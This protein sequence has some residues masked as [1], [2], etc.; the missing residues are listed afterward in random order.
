MWLY[1][2]ML[3]AVP[4]SFE[5]PRTGLATTTRFGEPGTARRADRD[6]ARTRVFVDGATIP[7][8]VRHHG[9]HDRR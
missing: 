1:G 8:V 4:R 3:P 2:R 7:A 6:L 9:D 5:K